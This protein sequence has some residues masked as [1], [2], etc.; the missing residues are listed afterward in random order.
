[1]PSNEALPDQRGWRAD[2]IAA[3]P[4]AVPNTAWADWHKRIQPVLAAAHKK[5]DEEEASIEAESQYVLSSSAVALDVCIRPHADCIVYN[6]SSLRTSVLKFAKHVKHSVIEHL[7]A[8]ATTVHALPAV[9]VL[10]IPA[11]VTG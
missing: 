6:V 2:D 7:F 3:R 8:V 9:R 5:L 1:M 10:A 4:K 11:C